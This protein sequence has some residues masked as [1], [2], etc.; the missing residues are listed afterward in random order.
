VPPPRPVPGARRAVAVARTGALGEDSSSSVWACERFD[1]LLWQLVGL[2]TSPRE[3]D[4]F[5][6]GE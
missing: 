5:L 6:R 1:G 3:R 4:A 2:V